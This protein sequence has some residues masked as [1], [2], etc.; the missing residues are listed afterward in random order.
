[1]AKDN[2]RVNLVCDTKKLV[3]ALRTCIDLPE[4]ITEVTVSAGID[5]VTTI[6]CT[7]LPTAKNDG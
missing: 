7:F 3:D 4:Y 6:T 5:K 2:I 1:M